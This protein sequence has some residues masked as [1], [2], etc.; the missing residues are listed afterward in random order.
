MIDKLHQ[1]QLHVG[2]FLV[3]QGAEEETRKFLGLQ[4]TWTCRVPLWS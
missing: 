4:P 3:Q 1:H 2:D